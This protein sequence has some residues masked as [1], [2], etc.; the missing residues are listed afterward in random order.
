MSKKK[1][2]VMALQTIRLVAALNEAWLGSQKIK[3][4]LKFVF[5]V[6]LNL[7]KLSTCSAVTW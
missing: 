1:V 5:V 4:G 3:L 7:F 6:K 2:I